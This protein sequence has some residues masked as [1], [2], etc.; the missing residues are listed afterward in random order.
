[1]LTAVLPGPRARPVAIFT[2]VNSRITVVLHY[3]VST[4]CV[5]VP[6]SDTSLLAFR[7]ACSRSN[8]ELYFIIRNATQLK[9]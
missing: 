9:A 3:D 5:L 4:L 8:E 7:S 6:V 1:M 2:E